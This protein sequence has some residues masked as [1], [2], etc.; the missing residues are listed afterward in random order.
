LTVVTREHALVE[1]I[2]EWTDGRFIGDDCA[3]L[4]GQQLVTAD[5]LVEGT[6]FLR[7][8]SSLEDIG[9]KSVAVNLSDIAAMAGR[10]RYLVVCLTLPRVFSKEQFNR[11]YSGII[12]CANTYKVRIVG[13][14]LTSGPIL[15]VNVT[16]IGDVHENGC[17]L[18]NRAKPGDI[19][20]VTG[21]FGA[22]TAGLWHLKQS[23]LTSARP[24][25]PRF[26]HCSAIHR[27]PQPKIA[28]AWS[29]VKQTN[30]QGALMDASDGLADALAQI[31]RASGVG[32]D[33]DLQRVPIHIETARLASDARVNAYDWALY[34]GEDYELVGCVPE[35]VWE[36][37]V[38]DHNTAENPFTAIGKVTD[39][40]GVQLRIGSKKGPELDIAKCFQQIGF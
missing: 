33:I 39:S 29:L 23:Q 12:D 30:G 24:S 36:S 31:S 38:N 34:G 40:G 35:T 37:W 25:A 14:D 19:V 26:L 27:R 21:N 18:R 28:E 8:L 9:W 11:L 22:S 20:V 15:V 1:Q 2:K 13:G 6:H 17:M 5:T 32:M 10:P 4:P 3:V 7:N 16:A